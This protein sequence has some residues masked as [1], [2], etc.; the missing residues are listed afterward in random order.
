MRRAVRRFMPG[1]DVGA[2]LDAAVELTKINIGSLLTQLGENITSP[3]EALAVRDHYL[4]VYRQ[5]KERKISAA[6]SVKLTQ[7]GLDMDKAA[8]I[9]HTR[10]LVAAAADHGSLLW[11]DMED[12]SYVDVTLEVF[13]LLRTTHP[14]VGLA[15]QAYLHRTPADIESLLPLAPAIRLVKGAYNEPA[16]IALPEKK[17]VDEQYFKLAARMLDHTGQGTRPVMGT[18]DMALVSRVQVYATKR[19]VTPGT[20]EVHMLYGIRS[21]EQ[22]ALA[23][24]GVPVKVL[25]SYGRH[26]FAWYMRRLAERP[27]NVWFVIRSMLA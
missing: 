5:L 1:E 23:G 27:A 21:A 9:E 15:I 17:D 14:N 13:R 24:A 18:H 2:A 10:A 7:L 19:Q 3:A 8:C 26:W 6:I 4:E 22:R 20:W 16:T 12:S 11:I 25:I